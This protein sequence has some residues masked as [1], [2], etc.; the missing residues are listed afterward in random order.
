MAFSTNALHHSSPLKVLCSTRFHRK[1]TDMASMA[2]CTYNPKPIFLDLLYHAY[3]SLS[4]VS[5]NK[6]SVFLFIR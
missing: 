4:A 6:P 3:Q 2:I 1:F 5:L